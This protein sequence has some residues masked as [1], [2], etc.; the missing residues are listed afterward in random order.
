MRLL[1]VHERIGALG[2]AEV[3]ILLTAQELLRRGHSVGIAH[4][5]R[6]GIDDAEWRDTF[7]Y[8]MALD[9][10]AGAG[11]MGQ[12]LAQFAPDVVYLNKFSE[13][14]V[15]SALAACRLPVIRMVHDHD[16][17]CMRSYKYH[18]LSRRICKRAASLYCMFP[19]GANLARGRKGGFPLR[20]VSYFAKRREIAANKK[21]H[22]MVVAS[23]YMRDELLRNGFARD[24]IEV[25][26]SVP[27]PTPFVEAPSF[28]RRNLIV[29]SGQV[30]RGKGVDVLLESLAL[31]KSPFECV[32][33][34]DGNQRA[35]CERLCSRLGLDG[36]VHFAGFVPQARVAEFYRDASLA[37]MSSVWPEPFGAAGLEAMRCGLPV[38][39]F[40]AGAIREWLVDGVTGFLVPWMDRDAF[41]AKVDAL[42]Q[43]KALARRLGE[44]GRQ[45]AD[46]RFN[47][48]SYIN[49]LEGLFA[50]TA[51]RTG[52][53]LAESA[54]AVP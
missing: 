46:E 53:A 18:Y 51:A 45:L 1:F 52:S 17:Y 40:D 24:R 25:H 42:L 50:R 29:Y 37:V 30:I 10:S 27:R 28:S 20:W 33:L 5:G 36:R 8:R 7:P 22:R 14:K 34:G 39:A 19:C 21:F 13:P 47:F 15:L 54:A 48:D 49:G 44:R 9:E 31:V 16:L 4:G 3:N 26:A 2:G 38:V 43:D 6:A 32:I 12:A 11:A 23:D 41:A 35:E